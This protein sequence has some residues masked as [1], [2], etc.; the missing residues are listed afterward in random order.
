MGLRSIPAR[1]TTVDTDSYLIHS[2][3]PA[4]TNASEQERPVVLTDLHNMPNCDLPVPWSN[5]ATTG[6]DSTFQQVAP[7]IGR[8]K[9]AIARHLIERHTMP[10][11]VVV[12]PFAGSGVVPFEAAIRGRRVVAGDINPYGVALT[13]AKLFAP[14]SESVAVRRLSRRWVAA[15]SRRGEQDL[16]R[17]PRWIRSFFHPETLRDALTLRDECFLRR[18]YFLLSCLMS[19][20]HHQRPGFLSYPSSH[21]VPYLRDRKFPKHLFPDLYG[22]REVFPRMKA[23]IQRMYRRPAF[24]NTDQIRVHLCDARRIPLPP[25]VDCVITSPPYMNELD[26]VRDNRLRIWFLSKTI[27][28]CPEHSRTVNVSTYSEL[29]KV[30]CTRLAR[31]MAKGSKFA[32]VVGE[33]TRSGVRVDTSA[34]LIKVFTFGI[35]REFRL[36]ERIDDEIPDI[37]RARRD[38]RGTKEEAV[39]VFQRG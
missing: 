19:I 37:R 35:L 1:G 32:F 27:D 34:L 30:T 29:I 5:G 15:Q 9:T 39:L 36:V 24:P 25:R 10:N 16:R 38:L 12:D 6:T 2:I 31:R 28:G 11:A 14:K 22:R 26:Y 21:L 3:P 4:S 33:A 13:R 7:Y 8:M 23:K 18:D 17:V 20:L